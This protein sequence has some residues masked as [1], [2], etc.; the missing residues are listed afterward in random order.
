M[1]YVLQTGKTSPEGAGCVIWGILLPGHTG[2]SL[3]SQHSLL[4]LSGSLRNGFL[5]IG[6]LSGIPGSVPFSYFWRPIHL[7]HGCFCPRS[8]SCSPCPKLSGKFPLWLWLFPPASTP[9]GLSWS[10]SM[11]PWGFYC[12]WPFFLIHRGSGLSICFCFLFS[13]VLFGSCL[14]GGGGNNCLS[15]AI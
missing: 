6:N 8:V 7:A 5:C 10:L 1:R 9:M 12:M 13:F 14:K 11:L 3:N 2:L 4:P 15:L